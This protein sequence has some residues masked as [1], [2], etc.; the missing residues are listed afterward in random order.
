MTKGTLTD[1]IGENLSGLANVIQW[2]GVCGSY[3]H[4]PKN[5]E[6]LPGKD[7]DI[8]I[9]LN[10][11][12][13][14]DEVSKSVAELSLRCKVLIHPIVLLDQDKEKFDAIEMYKVMIRSVEKVYESASPSRYPT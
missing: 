8:L 1:L 6:L 3:A 10:D 13:R 7:V 4:K 11:R 5:T 14:S 9:W 12:S 2:W